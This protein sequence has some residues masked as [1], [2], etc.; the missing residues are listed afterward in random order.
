M[1]PGSPRRRAVLFDFFGTLTHAVGRGPAHVPVCHALGV[2]PADLFD[3]LDRTFYARAAG[4]FGP[5]R[6]ALR[7]VL[8]LIGARPSEAALT[9]AV[10]AR[11]D[12]VRQ[13][14]KLRPEA[15]PLLMKLRQRGVRTALV[16]DCWYELPAFLPDLPVAPLLDTCVYSVD[17]GLCKPHPRMYLAACDRLG[18]APDEC[19]FVGDGGSR[20]LSGAQD[21]GISAV[22]LDAPDLGNHLVFRPQPDWSGPVVRSLTEV[23]GLVGKMSAQRSA[24][25][26]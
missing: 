18:V 19:L 24:V 8:A 1:Y 22:R 16:S 9:T 13:D 21:A 15:V 26:V 7:Q 2:D 11:I 23:L 4:A 20:E 12:A 10:R 5:P 17:I 3:V 14:A 6:E 25:L